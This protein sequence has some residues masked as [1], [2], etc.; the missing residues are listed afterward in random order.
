MAMADLDRESFKHL[1]QVQLASFAGR[2][3]GHVSA[4]I[5]QLVRRGLCVEIPLPDKERLRLRG[6]SIEV[7][8]RSKY[9]RATTK[10]LAALRQHE[11][12]TFGWPP[13]IQRE[14][15]GDGPEYETVLGRLD[16]VV[17]RGIG[18]EFRRVYSKHG[19][20]ATPSGTAA[21]RKERIKL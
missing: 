1:N 10:G 20:L 4:T 3:K 17:R 11:Q 2:S 16:E 8:N 15:Q 21:T 7:N 12:I 5:T 14:V 13:N 18:N 6:S 19:S 9:F